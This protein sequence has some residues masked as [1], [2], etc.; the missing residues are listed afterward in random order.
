[1]AERRGNKGVMNWNRRN[2]GD[3][4]L[5]QELAAPQERGVIR[6]GAVQPGLSLGGRAV[7]VIVL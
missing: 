7:N 1:M 2:K 5:E 3:S 6:D 4:D